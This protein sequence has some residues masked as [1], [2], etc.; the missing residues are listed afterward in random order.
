MFL[1]TDDIQ[2]PDPEM[3]DDSG[4][5]ALG[6][7]LSLPRLLQAYRNGIFPW[8]SPGEWIQWW[9]PDPRCVLFPDQLVVSDSMRALLRKGRFSFRYNTCFRDVMQACETVVRAEGPGSWIG[10]EMREAYGRLHEEGF[11]ISGEAFLEGRLVGGLYG[12]RL[13]TV[14]F[15]ESMF[16]H[17]SNASKF[18][19]IRLVQQLQ[20]EG[21]TLIDCQMPTRH[22]LSLGA[23]MLSRAEFLDRIRRSVG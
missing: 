1:L 4:L 10:A 3:A 16:H 8:F 22:L 11:V 15:G 14:F 9:S 5:L 13:G 6:G 17:V 21:L 12:V 19:F 2:F 20:A 7:D 23:T 18:A